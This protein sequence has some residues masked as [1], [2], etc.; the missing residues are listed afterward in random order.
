MGQLLAEESN[1]AGHLRLGQSVEEERS[2]EPICV[3]QVKIAVIVKL[4]LAGGLVA[5][6]VCMKGF[7]RVGRWW[8]TKPWA[9]ARLSSPIAAWKSVSDWK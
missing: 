5:Q 2:F 7:Q 8:V 9:L 3:Q 6:R 4:A 1:A